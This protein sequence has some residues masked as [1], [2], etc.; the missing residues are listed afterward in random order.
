[1][2]NQ[3]VGEKPNHEI[4]ETDFYNLVFFSFEFGDTSLESF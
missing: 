3:V 1:M 2:L 4:V